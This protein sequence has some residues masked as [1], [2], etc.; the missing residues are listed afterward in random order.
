MV[1]LDEVVDAGDGVEKEP[2]Y[3]DG[4]EGGANLAGAKGLGE[5]EE[6]EDRACDADDCSGGDVGCRDFDSLDGSENGLCG[7]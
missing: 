6:D 1:E 2:D 7:C 4:R 3:N 5:K